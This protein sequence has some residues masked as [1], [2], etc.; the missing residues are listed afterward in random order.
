MT[1]RDNSSSVVSSRSV[2]LPLKELR[3][4]AQHLSDCEWWPTFGGHFTGA[5]SSGKCTC[6][7]DALLTASPAPCGTFKADNVPS[8][9]LQN[10]ADASLTASPA[11]LR[12]WQP[13]ETAPKDGRMVLLYPSRCWVEECDRG[14]VGYWDADFGEWGG[15]GPRAEDYRGPTHWMPLPQ[16]PDPPSPE[17]GSNGAS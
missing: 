3:D 15:E 2:A 12:T 7:L 9:D 17:I 4:Y 13:I 1:T 11:G 14:E 6:G 5:S 8:A 16:P 10:T